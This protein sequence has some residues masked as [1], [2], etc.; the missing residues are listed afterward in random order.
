MAGEAFFGTDGIRDRFGEG[1]LAPGNLR[2][3]G[4]AI[5]AFA[6]ERVAA[7]PRL[8]VGRDTRPSGPA[9][10]QGIAE[11]LAAEGLSAEDGGVL[12]TPAV[13]WWTA[14]DGCDVGIALT[15]SHNPPA[16]NGVKVFLP[17]GRKTT[18]QEEV[19]LD[20][21]IRAASE[22]GRP[23]RLTA[24]TAALDAYVGAV[25]RLTAPLGRLDGLTLVVDCANGATLSTAPRVLEMLGAVVKG[26][27]GRSPRGAINDRCG[28]QAPDAWLAEV[29]AE[30]AH[31]GFAFDGDGDRV[32]LSD[33]GGE[34][35]DGDPVL[36]LLAVDLKARGSLTG[37][38]VVATVMANCGLESALAARGIRLERVPVGDRFVSARMRET[39]A[40]LGGEPSGHVVLEW[41][42]ALVGDGLVAGILAVQAARRRGMALSAC[43]VE[44][45]KWPQKLENVRVARRVPLDEAPAF[46][47]AVEDVV[48]GLDGRGRVVVRYS[49]TEPL[50]RIMVE[51]RDERTVVDAVSRLVAA[52]RTIG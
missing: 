30:R 46:Q 3:I 19:D 22:E 5:A 7:A 9:L 44:V 40:S 38:L 26:T 51:A 23:A 45:E 1:R 47:A 12:P 37:D 21:R 43:R 49:G 13:A 25:V 33:E 4:R 16:D 32:L 15:A 11:G 20:A 24:R 27:A 2:R 39:K 42:G 18:P 35:L 29:R 36:H 48:R 52:A 6:K 50:L 34:L 41:D 17:G 14:A 31:A 28:T 10:L 8:F